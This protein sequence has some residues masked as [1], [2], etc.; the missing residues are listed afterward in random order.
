MQNREMQDGEMTDSGLNPQFER[1]LDA[2]LRR[3]PDVVVPKHFSQRAL[4]SQPGPTS[5]PAAAARSSRWIFPALALAAAATLAALGIAAVDVG[6]AQ[7]LTQPAAIVTILGIESALSLAW[8][9]RVM[10][11]A[12]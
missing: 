2:A 11:A 8:V 6:W 9:W 5:A 3:A 1:D 12:R 7:A 4:A 10:R